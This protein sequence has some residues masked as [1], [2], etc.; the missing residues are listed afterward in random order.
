M[1][2]LSEVPETDCW[3][4]VVSSASEGGSMEPMC[5]LLRSG[6]EDLAVLEGR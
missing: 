5:P 3:I 1:T 4:R 6:H 2:D